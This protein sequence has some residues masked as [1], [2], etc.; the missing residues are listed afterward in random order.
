M[1]FQLFSV[2]LETGRLVCER[3]SK[4]DPPKKNSVFLVSGLEDLSGVC[5]KTLKFSISDACPIDENTFLV[6]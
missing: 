2:R 6:L 4:Q 3:V 5:R 1:R